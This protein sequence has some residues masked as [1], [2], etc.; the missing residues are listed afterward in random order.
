MLDSLRNNFNSRRLFHNN[1]GLIFL[2]IHKLSQRVSQCL[3]LVQALSLRRNIALPPVSFEIYKSQR[4][5]FI[6]LFCH[7]YYK[8]RAV[9]LGP[10]V[11]LALGKNYRLSTM[12]F[13]KW[14]LIITSA[15]PNYYFW[16]QQESIFIETFIQYLM[17]I[18]F[19]VY[20]EINNIEL[21][22]SNTI[23]Y[24]RQC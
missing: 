2:H 12:R 22:V 19:T 4:L 17:V 9:N 21:S 3:L 23:A 6:L 5:Y 24:I 1:T 20:F 13:Q 7:I 18:F 11:R 8:L 15:S 10:K 16:N 14:S